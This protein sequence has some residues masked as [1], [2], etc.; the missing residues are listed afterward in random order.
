MGI[1]DTIKR[2]FGEG[3]ILFEGTL[4]DGTTFKG[5]VPYI[6]DY[7]TL[8][9]EEWEENICNQIYYKHNKRVAKVRITGRM[10][11]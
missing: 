4:V 6:G 8:D 11:K 2:F 7:N 5:K 10:D 9:M 3:Y 1:L